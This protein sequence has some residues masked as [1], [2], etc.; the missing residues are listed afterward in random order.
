MLINYPPQPCHSLP[1]FS[2]LQT[3]NGKSL[4]AL[5][6]RIFAPLAAK[7][8]TVETAPAPIMMAAFHPFVD[9]QEDSLAL[10][11]PSAGIPSPPGLPCLD[12]CLHPQA[13]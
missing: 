10:A 8:D 6:G 1:S 5:T 3:C 7:P 2:L 11:C 13:G 4:L 12:A 9:V